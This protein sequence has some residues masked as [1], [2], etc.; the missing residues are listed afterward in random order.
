[1]IN[2]LYQTPDKKY[3]ISKQNDPIWNEIFEDV[4]IWN[5]CVYNQSLAGWNVEHPEERLSDYMIVWSAESIEDCFRYLWETRNITKEE[6]DLSLDRL[7]N[8]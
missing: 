2:F 4:E 3:G 8:L 5:V 1:M 7:K 6:Y